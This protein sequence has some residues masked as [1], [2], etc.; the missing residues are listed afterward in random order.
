MV[1]LVYGVVHDRAE[2]ATSNL[3]NTGEHYTESFKKGA[4]RS[5]NE[6]KILHFLKLQMPLFLFLITN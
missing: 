4:E 5:L 3:R 6:H 2:N 1:C